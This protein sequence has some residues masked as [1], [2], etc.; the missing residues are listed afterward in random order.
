VV[1]GDRGL[2]CWGAN[3]WGQL[4]LGTSENVGDDETPADVGFVPL[5]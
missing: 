4:G 3:G 5:G 1:D 2:V